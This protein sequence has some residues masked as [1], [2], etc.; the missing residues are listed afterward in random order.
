MTYRTQE[1]AVLPIIVILQWIQFR[2]GQMEKMHMTKKG[3]G[4]ER[5]GAKTKYVY[6]LYHKVY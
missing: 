5:Q 6:L 3:R 2:D 4:R 1:S